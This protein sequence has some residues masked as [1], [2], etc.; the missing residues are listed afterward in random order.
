MLRRRVDGGISR[1]VPGRIP[2]RGRL[3]IASSAPVSLRSR[4]YEQFAGQGLA[5]SFSVRVGATREGLL[6][7]RITVRDKM[8]DAVIFSLIPEDLES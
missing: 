3:A 8:H 5:S 6:R 2:A 7:H 4:G 1:R